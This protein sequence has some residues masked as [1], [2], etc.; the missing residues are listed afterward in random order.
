MDEISPKLRV[1]LMV[2]RQAVI[3]VLGAL[4]DFLGLERSITPKHK[5]QQL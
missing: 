2:I 5:R 1:F 4:E 3:I